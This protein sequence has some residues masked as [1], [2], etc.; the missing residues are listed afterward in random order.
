MCPCFW[1]WWRTTNLWMFRLGCG[2]LWQTE[3][4]GCWVSAVPHH[5]NFYFVLWV[6]EEAQVI[7]E[8]QRSRIS[9]RG[10]DSDYG[11]FNTHWSQTRF[12]LHCCGLDLYKAVKEKY[13]LVSDCVSHTCLFSMQWILALQLPWCRLWFQLVLLRFTLALRPFNPTWNVL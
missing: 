12:M 10:Q 3:P 13:W 5:Q 11:R 8:L 2:A 4:C 9:R 6:Y 1:T 7:F